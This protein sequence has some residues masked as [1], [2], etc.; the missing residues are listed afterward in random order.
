LK[1]KPSIILEFIQ[2]LITKRKY[3]LLPVIIALALLAAVVLL[4]EHQAIA[5]LIYALF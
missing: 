3:F 2:Y 5:P 1:G 4:L